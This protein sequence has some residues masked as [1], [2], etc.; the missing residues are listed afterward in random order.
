METLPDEVFEI[1]CGKL[2]SPRDLQ[3]VMLVDRYARFII[4]NS[5]CLMNKLPI[6][7]T[8]SEA[9]EFGDD[10]G[11]LI[12]PLMESRRKVTKVVVELKRE[13]MMKYLGI[14][15]KF[16]ETIRVLEIKGYAF[17]TTD[18]L[19]I[20]LRYLRNLTTLK[21]TKV[22]FHKSENKILNSIVQIP[23]LPLNNLR[24]FECVNSDPKIF[25]LFTN[26][27]DTQLRAIRLSSSDA[28]SFHYVDFIEMMSHQIKLRE[29]T[30]DGMTS[31]NC[32]ILESENFMKCQLTSMTVKN[33]A[34]NNKSQM[35]NLISTIKNQRKLKTLK[36]LNTPVPSSLDVLFTY[37][38]I[39]SNHLNEAQMDIGDLSFFHSHHFVNRTISKL[40]LHGNFAFENLPIFI[41]FIKMFPNCV[42]LKLVG[43]SPISD[44]YLFQILSLFRNLEELH[45]PGFTS[46]TADSNFANLSSL[47]AKLHTLVLDYIDYDVK[48]FGW[49]NIVSNLKSIEKLVIKRDFGKVSNEIVD[50]IVKTLK[51]RHLELGIGVVSGEILRT[52]IYNSNCCNELKV[53]KIAKSDFVK[54]EERIDFG[55]I[56]KSNRLLLQLCEDC[57]F[58]V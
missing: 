34:F 47:D 29:F 54:I 37:R 19:R 17:E 13:K 38:Q 16:S 50:V 45:V 28:Q 31:D 26:N 56:L 10:N 4:E 11:K 7:V 35:R 49:K 33:C 14:F 48:F 5:V 27:R 40:T 18:Q 30:I 32:D 53:L 39:F 46:R 41:N 57:Y 22:A 44:K 1:I 2:L 52:I 36:I 24:Q 58:D 43:E 55:K 21:V 6:F 12:E 8:D 3:N 42:R 25:S 23:K 51:L 9:D 20:V 15:K